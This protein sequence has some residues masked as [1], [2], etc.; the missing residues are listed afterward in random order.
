[1]RLAADK[2]LQWTR[3]PVR[4]V[5]DEFKVDKLDGW[6]IDFLRAFPHRQRLAAIACKGPGKVQPKSMVIDTP[7][8]KR[9]WGSLKAGDV[10]F[11]VDGSA[12]RIVETFDNGV[13]PMYRITFDDGSSTLAG[14]DHLWKVRGRTERRH[15]TWAVLTTEQ[16]IE[17][18]VREKNGKW[19]G[20]HFEIPRHGAVQ[21]S[22][23]GVLPVD[24]YYLGVW[25]GDGT[26][27]AGHFTDE[28]LEVEKELLARGFQLR[29]SMNE[30]GQNINVSVYGVRSALRETGVMDCGSHERFIPEPYKM[31]SIRQ[32]ID[33]LSG[34]MDTDGTID[35]DGS[36][37]YDTTSKRLAEDVVWLVRSLGGVSFIKGTIKKT[38]YYSPER[39]K[40]MGKDC[41]RVTLK[42]PFNPFHVESKS[43]RWSSPDS[44]EKERYLKRYIDK[45]ELEGTSDCMCIEIEHPSHCYL[46]NDF[47]VT[48]NTAV[49]AW[50]CWNF[51]GT[52][53]DAKIL[54]TGITEDNLHDNLWPEM[55]KWQERSEYFKTAFE[56]SKTRIVCKESPKNWFMSLR[57]WARTADKQKQSDALAGGHAEF[58]M[59][60]LEEA[61]GIPDAVAATAEAGLAT[62]TECKLL[63]VGNPTMLE[64]PLYRASKASKDLWYVVHITGDPKDPNRS[65][66][67]SAQWAQEQINE[68]GAD[69][70]WVLVNVFG[71]FPPSSL[72]VL[73]GPE[74]VEAAMKRVPVGYQGSQKRLGGDMA[75]FGDD[76]VILFPRQGLRAFAPIE[77]RNANG[78]EVAAR[79]GLAK[80]N[81]N[82]EVCLLDDTG[83]WASSVHDSMIQAGMAPIPVNFSGKADDV[84]YLNRRAEMHFRMAQWVK[85]GGCLPRTP[86]LKKELTSP[87]YTYVNG[88]FQIEEKKMIKA[89][90][91]FSPDE[92]D[93]LCLT[94]AL[95]ELASGQQMKARTPENRR[96]ISAG[97]ALSDYDPLQEM[98]GD[99]IYS[100]MRPT[101]INEDDEIPMGLI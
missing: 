26:K 5:V 88:K 82:W 99:G 77:M 36:M 9:V 12:T 59:Y 68:Y 80:A 72:N 22:G 44:P 87:T 98:S 40:I 85:R 55:S 34:L 37:E 24:P 15:G 47:I 65:S 14:P 83:G 8:G 100:E 49:T 66:R 23:S 6:Q 91:G 51:L 53:P 79:I 18:G 42:L 64:G 41:Y 62:G 45:I 97:R 33:L 71:Q 2:L 19:A 52:R 90:L 75:R 54:A 101:K 70:P 43:A 58:M 73:L 50:C 96:D 39:V 74:E 29:R 60:V 94:F 21:Y 93:G 63:C 11:A 57:T 81:W 67:V 78:P 13:L 92:S 1:M 16:I 28:A 30:R 17:R 84:R 3:D 4:M 69:N 86:T 38:F 95:P 61:G 7:T 32:R 56:W 27:G 25:I 48:H 31:A 89:R 35:K 46:A 10:V 20:R 76:R